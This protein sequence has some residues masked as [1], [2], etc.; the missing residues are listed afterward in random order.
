M[1]NADLISGGAKLRNALKLLLARW[2]ETKEQWHDPVS[3][4]FEESFIQLLEPE[5][6]SELDRLANL[7]QVLSEAEHECSPDRG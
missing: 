6:R 3:R 7:A 2:E 1:R 4:Q 5:I